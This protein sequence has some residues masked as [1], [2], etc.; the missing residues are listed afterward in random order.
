ME[1]YV[2]WNSAKVKLY[3]SCYCR[4][5]QM[6]QWSLS[7]LSCRKGKFR[8]HTA[9]PSWCAGCCDCTRSLEKYLW[10]KLQLTTGPG[11]PRELGETT[12]GGR[13]SLHPPQHSP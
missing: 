12:H 5:T 7:S 13:P 3:H 8:G 9:L 4:D 1:V 6:S 11:W 10:S 2:V